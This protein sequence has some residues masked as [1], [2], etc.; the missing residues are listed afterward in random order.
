[1]KE[2]ESVMGL[3]NVI[4]APHKKKRELS[5]IKL[6]LRVS[7]WVQWNATSN[8]CIILSGQLLPYRVFIYTQLK[9]TIKALFC[10]QIMLRPL[11]M[12]YL[13]SPPSRSL[14]LS[15]LSSVNKY[16]TRI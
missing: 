9:F 3:R 4:F 6:V 1:M 7:L 12:Y 10:N 15:S 5:F 16:Q 8:G 14:F 2:P 13:F 11:T